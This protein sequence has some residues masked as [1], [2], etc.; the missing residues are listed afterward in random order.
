MKCNKTQSKWYNN[1]RGAS[2][3]IDTFETYQYARQPMSSFG[4]RNPTRPGE[5][6]SGRTAV[7][8][9]PRSVRPPL[10]LRRSKLSNTKNVD[11]RKTETRA[12]KVC[13]LVFCDYVLLFNRPSP[14]IYIRG[15][16]T[17]RARRRLGFTSK[18]LVWVELGWAG[19]NFPKLF[20]QKLACILRGCFEAVND[21][22]SKFCN[23]QSC[24]PRKNKELLCLALSQ[25]S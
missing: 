17:S 8:G 18:T 22:R 3:I 16:W 25:L 13:R 23:E 20:G 11:E 24:S 4:T 1:K 2:K 9:Y 21:L 6:L 7:M 19:P 15:G 5:T 14:L 10:G 12:G